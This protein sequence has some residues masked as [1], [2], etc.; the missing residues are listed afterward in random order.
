MSY[1]AFFMYAERKELA[2]LVGDID[3]NYHSTH[4]K[5]RKITAKHSHLYVHHRKYLIKQ[6]VYAL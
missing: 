5:S 1:N 4:P 3:E 6:H 2:G